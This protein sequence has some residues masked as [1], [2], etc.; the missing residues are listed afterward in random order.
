MR[1]RSRLCA[2]GSALPALRS[3][4]ADVQEMYVKL[5]GAEGEVMRKAVEDLAA[6]RL[7]ARAPPV[8]RLSRASR[9]HQRS[10]LDKVR[11]PSAELFEPTAFKHWMDRFMR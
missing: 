5:A 1:A 4:L 10:T 2:L 3:R 9:A 8:H 6:D 11:P 7:A